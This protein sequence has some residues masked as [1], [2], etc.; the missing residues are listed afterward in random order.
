MSTDKYANISQTLADLHKNVLVEVK[1]RKRKVE[2]AR[3]AVIKA[4]EEKKA[5]IAAAA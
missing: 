2:N 3:Q 5:M 4:A 1:T